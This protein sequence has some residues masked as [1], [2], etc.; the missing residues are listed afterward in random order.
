LSKIDL[1]SG[2]H[3]VRIRP[4]DEWKT[5]FK[6][7]Y[8][9]FEWM[10]MPFVLF[11]APATFVRLMNHVRQPFMGK[12][13]LVYFDDI[14]V[15]SKSQHDHVDHLGRLFCTLKEAKLFVN[16]KKCLSSNS[17]PIFRVHNY[18]YLRNLC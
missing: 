15:Y 18:V 13:L 2:Y 3:Q 9:L 7:R 1:H 6:T 11:N 16:L 10:A 5:A 4:G 17:C 14:L 8:G 12:F